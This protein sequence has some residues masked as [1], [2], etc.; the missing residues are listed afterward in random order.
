M[1]IAINGLGRIGRSVLRLLQ[2]TR[3][4]EGF[5]IVALNDIAR[6]EL[7][8]YLFKYDSVFGVWPGDVSYD[9]TALI[10]DGKRFD[11]TGAPDL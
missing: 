2:S 3:Q 1:R 10:L 9:D 8:A 11:L 4:D 7:C 6:P 5:E